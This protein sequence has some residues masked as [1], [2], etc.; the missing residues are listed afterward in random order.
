[1][2]NGDRSRGNFHGSLVSTQ[3]ILHLNSNA[4]N[5]GSRVVTTA[6]LRLNNYWHLDIIQFSVPNHEVSWRQSHIPDDLGT[7][8]LF[9]YIKCDAVQEQNATIRNPIYTDIGDIDK[10]LYFS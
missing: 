8:R 10:T 5:E 6:P 7:F 9:R 3:L 1:M 2:N 4:I